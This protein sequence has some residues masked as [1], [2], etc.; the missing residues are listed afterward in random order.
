MDILRGDW[1]L[2]RIKSFAYLAIAF[3]RR[4]FRR[5]VRGPTDDGG[6]QRFLDNFSDE[7]MRPLDPAHDTL[8]VEAAGCIQCGLC[9]AVCPTTAPAPDRWPAYA[10]AL[11]MAAEAAAALPPSCPDG[12]RICEAACPTGVPLAA[13]PS[14]VRRNDG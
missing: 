2:T 10:R 3:W 14:F 8:I 5:L 4:R 11:A 9:E 1:G 13:I 6:A 7:G 12:C